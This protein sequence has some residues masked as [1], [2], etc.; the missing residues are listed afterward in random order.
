MTT[1]YDTKL[2]WDSVECGKDLELLNAL[3]DLRQTAARILQYQRDEHTED[4]LSDT[5]RFICKQLVRRESIN[6]GAFENALGRSAFCDKTEKHPF[7]K[8]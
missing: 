2:E 4:R 1:D 8:E 7:A 6:L 5:G 3:T